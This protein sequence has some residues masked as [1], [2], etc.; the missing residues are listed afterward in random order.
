MDWGLVVFLSIFLVFVTWGITR[1]YYR[2]KMGQ[3]EKELE[4]IKPGWQDMLS[5]HEYLV[6]EWGAYNGVHNLK[7]LLE[8][9]VRRDFPHIKELKDVFWKLREDYQEL[10]RLRGKLERSRKAKAM[11][12]LE[13]RAFDAE[14]RAKAAEAQLHKIREALG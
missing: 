6:Q 11:S 2:G 4:K 5:V 9:L 8:D 1:D 14:L 12:E 3:V 10:E 13:K 7:S